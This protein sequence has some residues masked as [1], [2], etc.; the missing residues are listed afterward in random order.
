VTLPSP[1]L[2]REHVVPLPIY[3]DAKGQPR[4]A[5]Q[6]EFY[7]LDER[8]FLLL[9]RV[10]GAGYGTDAAMSRY[11]K[12]EILDTSNATNI[13]ASPYD[14]AVPLAPMGKLADGVVPA[15][16]TSFIDLN[17]NTQLNA[18]GLYNS[19]PN[20]RKNRAKSGKG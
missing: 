19:E 14:G 4:V 8:H 2:A 6:S 18:F 5:P 11:R 20:D 1:T 12:I 7:A 17:D 16:L 3:D 15:T 13:A 9:C 10:G